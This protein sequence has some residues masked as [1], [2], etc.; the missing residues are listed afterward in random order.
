MSVCTYMC[1]VCCVACML[2][3]CM[4]CYCNRQRLHNDE[5]DLRK[6]FNSE[7]ELTRDTTPLPSGESDINLSSP[8]DDS[9]LVTRQVRHLIYMW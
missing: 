8:A 6:P 5:S 1:V 4:L 3:L 2:C 7:D 9:H